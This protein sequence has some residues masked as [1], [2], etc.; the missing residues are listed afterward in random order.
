MEYSS[1]EGIVDDAVENYLI[2]SNVSKKNNV[3]VLMHAAMTYNFTAILVGCKNLENELLIEEDVKYISMDSLEQLHLFLKRKSI[4]LVGVEIVDGAQSVLENPF[5]T[6]IAFM[7]GN[8]GTGLS[9]RQKGICDSFVYIPQYGSGT[10]S[11]N[12]YVATTIILHRYNAWVC[13]AGDSA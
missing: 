3:K 5:N 12:V 1:T 7:P 13:S 2:I 6:P 10:A 11:L 9:D 4:P 8:E